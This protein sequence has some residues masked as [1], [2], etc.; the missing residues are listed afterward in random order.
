MDPEHQ[1]R[2]TRGADAGA[3]AVA[4]PVAG[5]IARHRNAVAARKQ[6]RARPPR[7]RERDRRLAAGATRILELQL[8]RAGADRLHLA[9]DVGR[10]AV[11]GIE[12]DEGGR[13][14][15]DEH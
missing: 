6:Q 4:T 2:T 11:A 15:L 7:D 9:P 3:L 14:D 8:R 13:G 1:L 5:R 10:S 12:A